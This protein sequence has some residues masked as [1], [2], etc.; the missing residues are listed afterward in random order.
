[1]KEDLLRLDRHTELAH[2]SSDRNENGALY[3]LEK[4]YI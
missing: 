1:M 2:T 4:A 3:K